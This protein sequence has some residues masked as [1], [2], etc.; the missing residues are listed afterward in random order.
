MTKSK[1]FDT[2]LFWGAVVAYFLRLT[3]AMVFPK[4]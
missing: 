3:K 4:R 2:Y 1:R